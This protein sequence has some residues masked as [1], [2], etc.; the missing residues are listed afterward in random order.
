MGKHLWLL[1]IVG[2]VLCAGGSR[3]CADTVI[4]THDGTSQSLLFH[5][6]F[7]GVIRATDAGFYNFTRT[8]GDY[9]DSLSGAFTSFCIE[10]NQPVRATRSYNYDVIELAEAPFPGVGVGAGDGLGMGL[11]KATDI[12]RL[13]AKYYDEIGSSSLHAAAFQIAIWEIL[14][15]DERSLSSGNFQARY[16]S[17]EPVVIAQGW[18][19]DLS[20]SGALPNLLALSSPTAQDH[21]FLGPGFNGSE[22]NI[23]PLPASIWGGAALLALMVG[24]RVRRA[25]V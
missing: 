2:W 5:Y 14:Y 9:E 12:Q 4:A 6:R 24:Y 19:N 21:V 20:W 3:I 22:P 8:G 11:D 23:I 25:L 1:S 13:W 7:G 16:P 17:L 18:L 10:I 15:D